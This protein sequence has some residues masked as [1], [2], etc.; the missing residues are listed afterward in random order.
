MARTM[1]KSPRKPQPDK[2]TPGPLASI[3]DKEKAELDRMITYA[4][5]VI[6]QDV[7]VKLRQTLDHVRISGLGTVRVYFFSWA[8]GDETQ[9]RGIIAHRPYGGEED[10]DLA[11]FKA[12][13]AKYFADGVE[14]KSVVMYGPKGRK[15]R[16]R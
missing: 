3:S 2:R 12:N 13:M 16:L 8:V 7:K 9:E 5:S 11:Q 4:K 6:G 10:E 1:K 14:A 15:T